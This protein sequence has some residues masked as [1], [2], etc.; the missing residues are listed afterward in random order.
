MHIEPTH[1]NGCHI[2]E[3]K[4]HSDGRG[5]FFEI[6]QKEA[7]EA[8]G[9]ASEFVQENQSVSKK[10]VLRGLHFQ[11]APRGQAKLVRVIRGSIWDVAVDIDPKSST[12]KQWIGVELSEHNRRMVL[13]SPKMAHGFYVVSDHATVVY[14]CSDTYSPAHDA[15]IRWD[16]PE[17]GID[18]HLD[19]K[20]D[21]I[22]SGKDRELPL[23]SELDY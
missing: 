4:V 8:A 2:I 18:W 22:L 6:Y 20:V 9:V 3:P 11:K 23:L 5:I 15:G 14:L 16:D 21:V 10:G 1:L 7:Y 12:Y 13:L 17:F 19:P